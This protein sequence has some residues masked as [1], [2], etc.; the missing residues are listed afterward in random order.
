M[1]KLNFVLLEDTKLD[2]NKRWVRVAPPGR[3]CCALLLAKAEGAEQQAQ[4]GRQAGGTVFLFLYTDDIERDH[5]AMLSQSVVFV[6][7]P[8]NNPMAQ[9]PFSAT[10]MGTSGILSSRRLLAILGNF[11]YVSKRCFFNIF[12]VPVFFCYHINSTITVFFGTL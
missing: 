8:V 1:Q 7:E 11:K 4:V 12:I 10:C 2:E 9:L 3:S 5:A 6:R